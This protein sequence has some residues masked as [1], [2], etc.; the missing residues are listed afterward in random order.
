MI[1][2]NCT[3]TGSPEVAADAPG[4]AA[5][6]RTEVARAAVTMAERL[7]RRTGPARNV[8]GALRM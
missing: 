6:D 7:Q 4:A 2:T 3:G 5:K 8:R 1:D